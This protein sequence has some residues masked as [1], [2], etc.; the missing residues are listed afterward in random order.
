MKIILLILISLLASCTHSVKDESLKSTEV[1]DIKQHK[2]YNFDIIINTEDLQRND[3]FNY[4]YLINVKHSRND[5]GVLTFHKHNLL[6]YV[7]YHYQKNEKKGFDVYD[8][9]PVD[10]NKYLLNSQQLDSIYLLTS[11]LFQIDTLNLS[12]KIA[13]DQINYDGSV[14]EVELNNSLNDT[15]YKVTFTEISDEKLNKNFE[16]L[17]KYIECIKNK[18]P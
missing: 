17:L 6:Q 13:E 8:R 5:E 15:K 14:T 3:E 10:T 9:I 11:I 1:K 16:K 7:T 12:D 2:Y 4:K 18:T